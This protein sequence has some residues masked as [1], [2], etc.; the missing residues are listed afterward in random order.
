MRCIC[1]ACLLEAALH[2]LRTGRAGM[3]TALLEQALRLERE[4]AE[5]ERPA[6]AKPA[7]RA[8]KA[9]ARA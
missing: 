7:P 1:T 6:R 8:R 2:L 5:R 3:A 9:G 4:R